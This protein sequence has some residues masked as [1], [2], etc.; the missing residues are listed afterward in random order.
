MSTTPQNVLQL[1]R[2]GHP[3]AIAA[4]MNQH[5]QARGITAQVT[6]QDETLN[7]LLES[8]QALAPK[9]LL[10]FVEKGIT[11]LSLGHIQFLNVSGKQT[12]HMVVDWTET[13]SFRSNA[14]VASPLTIDSDNDQPITPGATGADLAFDA[15]VGEP[16]VAEADDGLDLGL[17]T[18]DL[19]ASL[20]GGDDF[21]LG[22]TDALDSSTD[23]FNFDLNTSDLQAAT[24]D[25]NAA[26]S[27][28]DMAAANDIEDS[29]TAVDDLGLDAD[30]N[31]INPEPDPK[32][33]L[34]ALDLDLGLDSSVDAL[35]DLGFP[36]DD[37]DLDNFELDFAIEDTPQT[38]D[39]FDLDLDLNQNPEPQS[40]APVQEDSDLDFGQDFDLQNPVTS[41]GDSDLDFGEAFD[42]AFDLESGLDLD[43]PSDA[44]DGGL[45]LD[46]DDTNADTSSPDPTSPFLEEGLEAEALEADLWEGTPDIS[47]F[48]QDNPPPELDLVDIDGLERTTPAPIDAEPIDLM[49]RETLDLS[50]TDDSPQEDFGLGI[51]TATPDPDSDLQPQAGLDAATAAAVSSSQSPIHKLL[52]ESDLRPQDP[53]DHPPAAA[54]PDFDPEPEDIA[55][56]NPTEASMVEADDADPAK[57]SEVA[58]D[59]TAD[60]AETGAL[61]ADQTDFLTPDDAPDLSP[62]SEAWPEPEPGLRPEDFP[63]FATDAETSLDPLD[64]DDV[65]RGQFSPAVDALDLDQSV[66]EQDLDIDTLEL[67]TGSMGQ[68][69]GLEDFSP[70][71]DF[72][73]T[74]IES[75]EDI[76]PLADLDAAAGDNDLPQAEAYYGDDLDD[77]LDD[78]LAEAN[79][80]NGFVSD[81]D[82]PW[83]KPESPDATD[84]FID[85]VT[86]DGPEPVSTSVTLTAEDLDNL[87]HGSNGPAVNW[88]VGL[89]LGVVGLGLA[90]IL[91]NTL[92]GNFRRQ[93]P[94]PVAETPTEM[95]V[96]A[97][98]PP[99]ATTPETPE[100]EPPA[101]ADPAPAEADYFREAVNAAQAAA[102]LT[103]TA[104]N[105]SEWQAVADSWSKAID[106]MKQ[107]PDSDPNYQVAQ[108]KAVEYQ[109]NLEYALQNAQ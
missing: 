45:T 9:E 95:P 49:L 92:W 20:L 26:L 25:L 23:D 64:F 65:D 55:A 88:L 104:S 97:D 34:E 100:P 33:D 81:V 76:E 38:S 10:A 28:L 5:L 19:E 105:S 27:D 62:D 82:A 75:F 3:D 89:G 51:D 46:A 13:V 57:G 56:V 70:D 98:E 8:A 29:W 83:D 103:Q 73:L 90:G 43:L 35:D 48:E 7:V 72:P 18:S 85:E 86:G 59:L 71:D 91:F 16:E 14:D 80:T 61:E 66:P 15:M 108:Q 1:A 106:L 41:Q 87:D 2:Q 58:F 68:F 39:N 44:A 93:A 32:T 69:S 36:A 77:G 63:I 67:D 37:D 52:R 109:P 4:L 84:E 11:G 74:S 79:L 22:L 24:D 101:P 50:T 12:G 6:Q 21:D 53:P 94:P 17:D 54:L 96:P 30:P 47:V 42:E 102:N 31:L 40:G 107:V 99:E 78:D 60:T